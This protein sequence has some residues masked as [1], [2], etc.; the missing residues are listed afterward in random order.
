MN[1]PKDTLDVL[2]SPTT[3]CNLRCRY[4]YVDRTTPADVA[5]MSLS[6][7]SAA[8]AWLRKY[9][10]V[11]GAKRIR[12]TWFGGEPLLLGGDFLAAAL[13]MQEKCLDG[14]KV[15]NNIQ[16]NLTVN[17]K[18]CIPLFK[19]CFDGHVGFSM[20]NADGFRIFHD[21]GRTRDVVER[22]VKVL[23]SVGISTGAV[24]TLLRCD[25]GKSHEIYRYFKDLGVV[26]RVNRAASSPQLAE[27]GLLLSV[28]EYETIVKEIT[29]CY[30]NDPSPTISFHN[31]DMMVTSYLT[32]SAVL[33]V[34][35]EHPEQYIGLEANGRIMSRCRFKPAMGNYGA[36]S[37]QQVFDRF[38][39]LATPH[40][41]PDRCSECEFWGKV[42][43]GGC[44]GEPCCD[45]MA[46]DCGYRTEVT[47]EL[48][49]F[50]AGVL[51]TRGLEYGS[52]DRSR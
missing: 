43:L 37:A 15:L 4:C 50:V 31:F 19:R 24:C 6:D 17:V 8:F 34:D 51:K 14:F 7:I 26:F 32:G 33:C 49:R 42:C 18:P 10:C 46:S 12:F 41:R 48:W 22:N 35:T 9:A 39:S 45:C 52:E 21:G 1:V 2:L 13:E 36:D 11:L 40:S 5:D 25:I 3:R 30:L 20:D 44:I 47:C 27:A 38:R 23:Q 28:S 29:E 16:S